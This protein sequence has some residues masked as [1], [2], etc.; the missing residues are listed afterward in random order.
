MNCYEQ[1]SEY[2]QTR[3]TTAAELYYQQL[4]SP[5]YTSY[6]TDIKYIIKV[7]VLAILLG[8]FIIWFMYWSTE[9]GSLMPFATLSRVATV[10]GYMRDYQD[11][12][13]YR[14]GQ[15]DCKDYAYMF[16]TIW[17]TLFIDDCVIKYA[18]IQYYDEPDVSYHLMVQI[19]GKL[20]EPCYYLPDD[21]TQYYWL[22][23]TD[24]NKWCDETYRS[25]SYELQKV[26]R[27]LVNNVY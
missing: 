8:L 19:N 12:D 15:V 26:K 1:L 14:D 18:C 3:V 7:F 21:Y 27:W 13:V 25:C 17:D 20:I 6:K 11:K 5:S 16:K 22:Y 4:S 10:K 24:N 9:S 2:D 23:W